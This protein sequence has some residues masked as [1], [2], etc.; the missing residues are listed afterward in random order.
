MTM[1]IPS[2]FTRKWLMGFD[3]PEELLAT[4]EVALCKSNLRKVVNR[5]PGIITTRKKRLECSRAVLKRLIK[6]PCQIQKMPK[7]AERDSMGH[8]VATLA[9]QFFATSCMVQSLVEIRLEDRDVRAN[10]FMNE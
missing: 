10:V 3:L 6:M 8:H 1:Y 9:A 2:G 5:T 7:I 4:I